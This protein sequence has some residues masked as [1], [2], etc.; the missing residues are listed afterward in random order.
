MWPHLW[1]VTGA[2]GDD[3]LRPAGEAWHAQLHVANGHFLTV[4][5]YDKATRHARV[6][7]ALWCPIV[8]E[9]HWEDG[10]VWKRLYSG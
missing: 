4:D 2:Y 8:R 1:H 9:I 10:N 7:H 3:E 6:Y 5:F